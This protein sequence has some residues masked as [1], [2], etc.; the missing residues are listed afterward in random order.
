MEGCQFCEEIKERAL[1]IWGI[2]FSRH[3]IIESE[4]FIVIPTLGHIVEGYLLIVSKEHFISCGGIPSEMYPELEEIKEKVARILSDNYTTPLF[5]EHGPASQ[6]RKG[7]CCIDHAH[8]HAVPVNVNITGELAKHFSYREIDSFEDLK[9]QFEKGQHY[10]FLEDHSK[11]RYLFDLPDV[12]PSQYI[13]KVIAQKI[14]KPERWDWRTCLG[15][16]ELAQTLKKLSGKF[17]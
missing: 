5:F 8:I 17:E 11:K 14:G 2:R 9:E 4:N 1:Q 6:N 10:F 12:V 7:G 16:D 13:R 15:L 3:T